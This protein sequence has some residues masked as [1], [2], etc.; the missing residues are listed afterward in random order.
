MTLIRGK[1]GFFFIFIE[2]STHHHAHLGPADQRLALHILNN[3]DLGQ[4]KLVGEHIE[5]RKLVNPLNPGMPQVG[6]YLI[7]ELKIL[8]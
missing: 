8:T 7:E 5:T 4:G 1:H 6:C 3:K 2:E